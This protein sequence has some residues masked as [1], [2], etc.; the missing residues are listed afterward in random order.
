VLK[1]IGHWLAVSLLKWA[2]EFLYFTCRVRV[3]EGDDVRR[4]LLTN[5]RPVIVL[6]WH[7]RIFTASPFVKNNWFLRGVPF[8][9]LISQSGDGEFIANVVE[10]WGADVARGSSSRGGKEALTLLANALK[11][12]KTSIIITPDGP[13]GP[14]YEFQSGALVASQLTQ[15]ELISLCVAPRRYWRLNSWDGL[16]MPKPFT[17]ILVSISEPETEPRKQTEEERESRRVYHENKM[18][19]QHRRLDALAGIPEYT[20]K[21]IREKKA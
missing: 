4:S 12:K 10:R 19:E 14:L 2:M 18:K 7:N 13:R 16:L 3:V 11:K 9:V 6:F 21:K 5:K 15:A 17:E 8:T 1:K 20:G